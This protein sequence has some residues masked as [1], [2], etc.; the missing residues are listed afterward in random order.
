MM[1]DKK[2]TKSND[3]SLQVQNDCRAAKTT[4]NIINIFSPGS[5]KSHSVQ[6]LPKSVYREQI[7]ALRM[8]SVMAGYQKLTTTHPHQSS[9]HWSRHC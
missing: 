9:Y 3:F 1:L 2:K 8:K 4:F 7:R 5:T 6:W